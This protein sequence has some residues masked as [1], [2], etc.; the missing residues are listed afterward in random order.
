MVILGVDYGDVRTGIAS[1]DAGGILASPV[2]AL[3]ETD[4]RRLAEKIAEIAKEKRAAM[5]VLGNPK[6]MDSSE[7]FRSEKTAAFKELLS[8]VTGLPVVLRDE[9]LSTVLA[10]ALLHEGQKYGKK[11]R[12][13]IDAASAAVILQGYL[14]EQKINS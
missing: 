9:R 10:N 4:A 5:I 8:E 6:N 1:C 2:C 13:A 12:K 14:D 3:R 11:N 7:G